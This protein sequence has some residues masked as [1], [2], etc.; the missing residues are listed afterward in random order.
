[1]ITETSLALRPNDIYPTDIYEIIIWAVDYDKRNRFPVDT[2]KRFAIG[3]YQIH[4]GMHW[5]DNGPNKYESFAAA[6][7]HFIIVAER[8]DLKVDKAEEMPVKLKEFPRMCINIHAPELLYNISGAQ[9]MLMYNQAYSGN[10][11]KRMSRYNPEILEERLSK[12]VR[13][14]I[15][16]IPL[17][18]RTECFNLSTKIMTKELK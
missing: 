15:C 12:I 1:M 9:A 10:K 14:L 3:L 13:I 16:C 2:L 11:T 5:K 4:Q 18:F 17:E 8:C 6:A 7:V